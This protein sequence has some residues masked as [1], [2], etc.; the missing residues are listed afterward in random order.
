MA[1][2]DLKAAVANVIKTN[3]TQA[4]TG[5]ALQST[6]NSIID[7]IGENATYKGVAIPTT[8]PGTPDGV[9]FYIA[10]TPG[11]YS[12]FGGY[13]LNSGFV[14]LSNQTGSWVGSKIEDTSRMLINMDIDYP[15]TSGYYTLATAIAAV[16][17][18]VRKDSLNIIFKYSDGHYYTYQFRG[19]ISNWTNASYW[20]LIKN[21]GNYGN[22]GIVT[23]LNT[24]SLTGNYTC[25]GT[26]TGAPSTEYSWFIEHLN[27][28]AGLTY[29]TQKATAFSTEIIVY[30]RVKNAGSWSDWELQ[31][32]RKE[33]SELESIPRYGML[34]G[35]QLASTFIVDFDNN[36]IYI[37]NGALLLFG[38]EKIT[39]AAQ[40]I[41]ISNL[42]ISAPSY[43]LYDIKLNTFIL[44]DS[45]SIGLFDINYVIIAVF[46]KGARTVFGMGNI[47]KKEELGIDDIIISP[48]IGLLGGN[49]LSGKAEISFNEKYLRFNDTTVF[50]IGKKRFLIADTVLDL[51]LLNVSSPSL[52]YYN[53]D[54]LEFGFIASASVSDLGFNDFIIAV[55]NPTSKTFFALFDYKVMDKE[56]YYPIDT[57]LEN[58]YNAPIQDDLS[59]TW[60]NTSYQ[61]VYDLYDELVSLYP[62]YLSR[63]LLGTNTVGYPIYRYDYIPQYN[64]N[65]EDVYHS[66]R[67][68]VLVITGTHGIEKTSVY[69]MYKLIKY[70]CENYDDPLIDALR[71]NIHFVIIPVLSTYAY[72]N[73]QRINENGVDLNRNFS[74]GWVLTD[75]GETYSGPY[76]FSEI[77]SQIIRDL[78]LSTRITIGV[79]FHNNGGDVSPIWCENYYYNNRMVAISR[80]IG[81]KC[82]R[83]FLK[84][85]SYYEGRLG[86]ISGTDGEGKCVS[87][88]NSIGID[89]ITF[90][91]GDKIKGV[92]LRN[93]SDVLTQGV[94]ATGNMLRIL[95][96]ELSKFI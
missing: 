93:T 6:L 40:N 15:L 23:D 44:M 84:K 69:C 76:A 70:I 31:P 48:R 9:V 56:V 80:M 34:A 11:T 71:G 95:I 4:I 62:A 58:Y 1:W 90:E 32:S 20:E 92:G 52:L 37:P 55:I 88:L 24:L 66:R 28:G 29:G 46:N 25:Y 8:V 18:A 83:E 78:C 47:R 82:T 50:F 41:D 38:K 12:N 39:I 64:I 7:Q 91:I 86:K 54:R 65:E 26:A 19:I 74:K 27:S 61:D 17:T 49:Q 22:V 43:L 2:T 89:S 59:S 75:I 94:E 67:M 63:T 21:V 68:N 13:I 14:I 51:S 42:S 30:K 36:I 85:Y 45:V 87:F 57:T 16:P 3:G 73:A 53:I 79:D 33:L 77:E 81:T 72:N 10:F 35:N 60:F 96:K 5:E